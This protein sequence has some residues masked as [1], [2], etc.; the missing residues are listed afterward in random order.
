MN[1]INRKIYL[2]FREGKPFSEAF[3]Q[4]V[5]IRRFIL[6]ETSFIIGDFP[7]L[8]EKFMLSNSGD[9]ESVTFL[10]ISLMNPYSKFLFEKF[11]KNLEF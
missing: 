7:F 5:E 6:S 4:H 1:K 8:K 10:R 9:E 11:E 3:E 2:S